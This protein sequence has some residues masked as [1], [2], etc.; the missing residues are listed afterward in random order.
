MDRERI[1]LR[2]AERHHAGRVRPA[3]GEHPRDRAAAALADDHGAPSLFGDQPLE[4]LLEPRDDA[5]EQSTLE[6][7]PA[8][9]GR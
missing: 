1:Q 7:I 6:R 8:R 9:L 3:P 4:P 2:R 5:P